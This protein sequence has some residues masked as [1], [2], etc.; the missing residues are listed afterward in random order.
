MDWVV[1]LVRAKDSEMLRDQVFVAYKLAYSAGKDAA[2]G[3][4]DD[5]AIRD[6]ERELPVLFDQND[7]LSFLFQ[8]FD[9]AS[10]L[11]HNQRRESLGRSASHQHTWLAT[12]R[13]VHCE[14]SPHPT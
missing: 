10:H 3:I 6:I 5:R 11:R 7:R 14:R 9:S 4:E 13:Q 12:H 1:R 8:A 2:P